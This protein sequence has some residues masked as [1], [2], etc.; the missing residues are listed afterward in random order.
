MFEYNAKVL[1]VV[2]GDTID[3]WVDLGFDSWKKVRIRI[4]KM[5]NL[6]VHP[7]M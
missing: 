1:K 3:A 2:D 5:T 7:W 6:P 4:R